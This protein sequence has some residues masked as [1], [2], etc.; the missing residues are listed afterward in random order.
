MTAVAPAPD[1]GARI[2]RTAAR[3]AALVG[4]AV[5]LGIVLVQIVNGSGVPSSGA[6]GTGTTGTTGA[7]AGTTTT[8]RL[9]GR[10]PADVKV[11]VYNASGV[12][13]AATT[14]ANKLRGLGYAIVQTTNAA[15]LQTGTTVACRA[16]FSVE[17]DTLA[18][19]V[20]VGA[21]V[22]VY[23]NPVPANANNADCIVT[24]GK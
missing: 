17:A 6:K 14:E 2:W 4:A 7:V 5:V 18:K 15:T 21:T 9:A 11:A 22:S 8:T 24:L 20:V 3:G 19:E 16:G 12:S 23:P 10:N 13:Q 1:F